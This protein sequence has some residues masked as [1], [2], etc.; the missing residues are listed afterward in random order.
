MAG[1]AESAPPGVQLEAP[2]GPGS[3]TSRSAGSRRSDGSGRLRFKPADLNAVWLTGDFLW[4]KL[5]WSACA[6]TSDVG[7]V[8][9]GT[10]TAR[11]NC[12]TQPPK[13]AANTHS[14]TTVAITDRDR[15]GLSFRVTVAQL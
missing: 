13:A 10:D 5:G 11:S 14:A 7:E 6:A 3:G 15:G 12:S 8:G 1:A 2:A 9:G 4:S